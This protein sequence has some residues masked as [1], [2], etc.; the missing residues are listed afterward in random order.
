MRNDYRIGFGVFFSWGVLQLYHGQNRRWVIP[1]TLEGAVAGWFV[2]VA[3][4]VIYLLALFFPIWPGANLEL[5]LVSLHFSL[6]GLVC[7]RSQAHLFP[8]PFVKVCPSSRIYLLPRGDGGFP[9][10]P[11]PSRLVQ[12]FSGVT[13]KLLG[14]DS[15]ITSPQVARQIYYY[16]RCEQTGVPFFSISAI[17][18][19]SICP[20][21]RLLV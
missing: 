7:N 16:S 19:Y 18:C 10:A 17:R 3:E 14:W 2:V 20:V 9:V 13:P 8:W 5:Y 15:I 1:S 11:L 6:E 4:P 21:S 12:V